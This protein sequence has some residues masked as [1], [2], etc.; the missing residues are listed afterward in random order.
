MR[1]SL[2]LI[3]WK[4]GRPAAV[5]QQWARLV[6]AQSALASL[7]TLGRASRQ[8]CD[9]L[10]AG[11]NLAYE[12][13]GQNGRP[14]LMKRGRKVRRNGDGRVP[15]CSLQSQRPQCYQRLKASKIAGIVFMCE[16]N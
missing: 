4:F 16:C 8:A 11:G 10:A 15:G 3:A 13:D 14:S 5:E 6:Q 12:D 7:V 9:K 1:H 2:S